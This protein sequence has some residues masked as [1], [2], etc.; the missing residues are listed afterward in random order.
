VS[1][2]VTAPLPGRAIPLA[3]VPDAV[4]AQAMVGPGMAIDPHPSPADAAAPVDGVLLKL[5]PHAF[6]VVGDGNRGVLVHL[7][8]DTVQLEGRGFTLL[9]REGD[10][11]RAGQ[12]LVHWDPGEVGRTGRSPI[13]PVVALDAA[14]DDLADLV[15][16]GE[17]ALATPVFTWR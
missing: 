11:V 7:G 3:S 16:S 10:A 14:P 1:L 4:F 8:I 9:A 2:Q 15:D 12:P 5:H 17:V 6:V 13:C